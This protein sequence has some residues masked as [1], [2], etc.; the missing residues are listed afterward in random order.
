MAAQR[1]VMVDAAMPFSASAARTPATV[2]GL[3]GRALTLRAMHKTRKVE[4]SDR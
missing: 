3:A 4:K 2:S 1:R